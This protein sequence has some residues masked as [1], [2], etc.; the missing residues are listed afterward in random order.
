MEHL[1]HKSI[2]PYP[3]FY[4]YLESK[5]DHENIIYLGK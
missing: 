1:P 3:L 4:T 5:F 2:K